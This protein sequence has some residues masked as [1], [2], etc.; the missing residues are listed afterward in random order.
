MYGKQPG[1]VRADAEVRRMAERHDT[2]VAQD[3]IE[4][5]REH[6]GNQDLA[7]EHPMI[8]KDEERTEGGEPEC[9]L[10]R[11]PAIGGKMWRA[12]AGHAR[13][14]YNPAG[15]TIISTTIST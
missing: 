3:E 7:P 13:L 11:V 8:R 6:S 15:K 10:E 2:R 12:G 14:P 1:G 4:R 9:D 5:H